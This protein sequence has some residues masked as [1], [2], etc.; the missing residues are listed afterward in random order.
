MSDTKHPKFG[1]TIDEF[2]E[3]ASVSRSFIRN[4]PPERQPRILELS[5]RKKF[6]AESADE[7][8]R[9]VTRTP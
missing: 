6:V 9:R 2:C 3:E 1:R 8:F 7:W 5:P 4:L